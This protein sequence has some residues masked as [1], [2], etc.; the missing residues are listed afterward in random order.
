TADAVAAD[1]VRGARPPAH[2]RVEDAPGSLRAGHALAA[3]LVRREARPVLEQAAQVDG[4]GNRDEA[5]VAEL[6]AAI[7]HRAV[8]RRNVPLVRRQDAAERAAEGDCTQRLA[9]AALEALCHLAP[10]VDYV[11]LAQ[12][13]TS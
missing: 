6:D 10:G 12:H 9:S 3:R 5:A 11:G 1:F 2:Q 7:A 8:A 13:R 4:L